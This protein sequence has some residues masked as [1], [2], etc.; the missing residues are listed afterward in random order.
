MEE[1]VGNAPPKERD[2]NHTVYAELLKSILSAARE[3]YKLML[4]EYPNRQLFILRTYLWIAVTEIITQI[5]LFSPIV[6][7]KHEVLLPWIV[8]QTYFFY[9]FAVAS[10]LCSFATFCLGV[11]SL[12]KRTG[13]RLLYKQEFMNLARKAHADALASAAKKNTHSMYLY[14]IEDTEGAIRHQREQNT[15]TGQRLRYMSYALLFSLGFSLVAVLP[16]C[17]LV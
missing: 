8:P 17:N 3:E 6:L 13:V 7:S 11:Y 4:L 1:H 14:M 9:I 12:R 10:L 2:F 15:I 16:I 5:S